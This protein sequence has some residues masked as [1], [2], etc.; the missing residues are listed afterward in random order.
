M[1]TSDLLAVIGAVIGIGGGTAGIISLLF[2]FVRD[3]ARLRLVVLHAMFGNETAVGWL[4]V[5]FEVSNVGIFPTSITG[6]SAWLLDGANRMTGELDK[7]RPNKTDFEIRTGYRP[8]ELPQM[9]IPL[10]QRLNAHSSE[11]Y[12]TIFRLDG[13]IQTGNETP[14]G[15]AVS[16]TH[17]QISTE[18]VAHP[19]P[20]QRAVGRQGE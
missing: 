8:D 10:P 7:L 20:I 5:R 13:V 15:L 9:A 6:L 19:Q 17:G 16:H 2:Q 4:D 1:S 18:A 14:C 11:I 3:K 12:T